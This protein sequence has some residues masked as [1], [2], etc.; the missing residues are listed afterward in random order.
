MASHN[1]ANIRA[2]DV[3][4][5][6]CDAIERAKKRDE[7]YH[8]MICV[9][10]DEVYENCR[11]LSKVKGGHGR[12]VSRTERYRR[13]GQVDL[14]RPDQYE[15]SVD[16]RRQLK[17]RS[18]EHKIPIQ[19]IRES[20]LRIGPPLAG[21]M[22]GLTPES[23]RAWNL[24]S[25]LV[26][27]A[28][29]KPWRLSTAR[30]GVCYIGLAFRRTDDSDPR[31]ACCAA[32]MFLDTGD[33]IVF[34][35]EF[36]PWYSP[37]AKHFHLDRENAKKLLAGALETYF[38][39]GGKELKEIFLHSRSTISA[40][41]FAGYRE[42]CPAGVKLVAVRVQTDREGL[43][44]FRGG[45][46]PAVRGTFWKLSERTAYLWASGFK[47]TL[48]TYDGWEVPAPLRIDIEHGEADIEQVA[49]DIFG[50]TKLNYNTCK[51][52]DALPVTVAFSDAVGEILIANPTV[53]AVSPNFK[54]YI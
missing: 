7:P 44:A 46:W 38:D 13:R 24:G 41:E 2:Y 52:G 16:F 25:T 33:G 28:G 18:M 22:R 19:I 36:G 14:L 5:T 47:P 27:K 49:L 34:K 15:L 11:P 20:T 9:I 1:D 37:D 12:A 4:S 17:A 29:A 21:N 6:Y 51:L 3:V 26:Y 30:E 45:E 42:A 53:K 8:V 48:M 54:F 35:G 32:Q 23:D 10:P 31:T 43:R 40:D 50:L 39:E